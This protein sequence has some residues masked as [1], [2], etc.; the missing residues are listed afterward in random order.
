MRAAHLAG[1]VGVHVGVPVA[2]DDVSKSI[3]Q[4]E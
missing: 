4:E 3:K 2:R 1:V